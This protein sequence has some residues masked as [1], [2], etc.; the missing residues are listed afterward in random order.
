ML[1]T[2]TG[3]LGTAGWTLNRDF[4]SNSCPRMKP[5]AA[6]SL[7]AASSAGLGGNARAEPASWT[8]ELTVAELRF[9]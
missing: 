6:T 5:N 2:V 1:G 3:L 7:G 8:S 9:L 4:V